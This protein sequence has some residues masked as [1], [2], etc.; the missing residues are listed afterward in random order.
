MFDERRPR[1]TSAAERLA[2]ENNS[3]LIPKRHGPYRLLSVG[4]EYLKLLQDNVESPASINRVTR[5]EQDEDA[6]DWLL[7]KS[8]KPEKTSC[9]PATELQNN[10]MERYAFKRTVGHFTI[11]TNA[12]NIVHWY[13]YSKEHDTVQFPGHFPSILGIPTVIGK[14]NSPT[15]RNEREKMVPAL[16]AHGW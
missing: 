2:A 12:R 8:V 7:S 15:P 10:N 3:R 16:K 13:S 4:R 11:K 14:N 6:P 9:Q 5:V 1:K